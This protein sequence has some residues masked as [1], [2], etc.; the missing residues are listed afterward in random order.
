M[1]LHLSDS[2]PV[3]D[4]AGLAAKVTGTITALG[5]IAVLFGY[6]VSGDYSTFAA[7]AGAAVLA[8]GGLVGAILPVLN[9]FKA[10]AKVTPVRSGT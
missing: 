6:G 2:E 5:T 10:R 7:A 8:F 1:A 3:I 9:A 4:A